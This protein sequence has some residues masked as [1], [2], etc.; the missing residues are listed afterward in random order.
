MNDNTIFFNTQYILFI[1]LQIKGMMTV[2]PTVRKTIR[3]V[4]VDPW[5]QDRE[6][7]GKVAELI[8]ATRVDR[9]PLLPR[10]RNTHIFDQP[11]PM[12]RPRLE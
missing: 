6:M 8:R 9:M 2:D 12:K 4:L 11:V 10:E 3:Q 5:L 1:L 7:K